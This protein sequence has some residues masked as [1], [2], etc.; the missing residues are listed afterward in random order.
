[1]S[2]EIKKEQS[3]IETHEKFMREASKQMV[4]NLT[5]IKKDIHTI[6]NWVLF[7]GVVAILG[8]VLGGCNLIMSF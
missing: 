3:A 6:A 4:D 2:E 8:A 7:F 1:M 5:Q